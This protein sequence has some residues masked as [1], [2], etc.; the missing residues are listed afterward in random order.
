MEVF[1]SLVNHPGE[2]E[3]DQ[4]DCDAVAAGGRPNDL[5]TTTSKTTTSQQKQV[6]TNHDI[7][8]T[9]TTKTTTRTAPQIIS[10]EHLQH[11]HLQELR[12][13]TASTSSSKVTLQSSKA[14]TQSRSLLCVPQSRSVVSDLGSFAS[15]EDTDDADVTNRTLLTSKLTKGERRKHF[16]H[17]RQRGDVIQH[18]KWDDSESEAECFLSP[19]RLPRHPRPPS[20]R[21]QKP[22]HKAESDEET[23]H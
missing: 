6:V 23:P 19:D 13:S 4:D 12:N 16:R 15:G 10:P 3:D 21:K 20:R 1:P 8:T 14:N 18:R 9:T 2:D 7:K 5:K 22:E 17:T 11:P